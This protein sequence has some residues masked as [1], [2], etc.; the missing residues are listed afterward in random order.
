MEAPPDVETK[1]RRR[2]VT[3]GVGRDCPV[4]IVA[5]K[6]FADQFGENVEAYILSVLSDVDGIFRAQ[7]DVGMSVL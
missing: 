6:T 4:A 5:D 7:L 2:G 1:L 3:S